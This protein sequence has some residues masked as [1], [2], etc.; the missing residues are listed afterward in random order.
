[1]PNDTIIQV[2]G[3][4]KRYGLRM[5]RWV[6]A[7]RRRHS[8]DDGPW[9]L[10]DVSLE[11][12]RGETVGVIGRNGAG[13]STLLKV[14]A[15]VTP[16]TRGR[17]EVGGSVFPMI[18]LNAGVHP[19]LSGRENVGLLG[20]IMGLTGRE[21]RAL[22]PAIEDFCEIGEWFDR[23]VRM[24]SSGMLAR[25]GLSV[26]LNVE[27]EILLVDEV[28]AVGD[29]NFRRKCV[30][31]IARLQRS[32]V[33]LLWVTHS[34]REAERMCDRGLLLEAGRLKREAAMGEVGAEY[35]AD[36][37]DEEWRRLHAEAAPHVFHDTGHVRIE[38]L[39]LLGDSGEPSESFETGRPM[40]IRMAYTVVEPVPDLTF[41]FGFVTSDLLRFTEFNS[42]D[43]P[44]P[45]GRDTRGVVE[46]R[47]PS[48]PL[49]PGV[50]GLYVSITRADLTSF[51]KGE[52]VKR[53]RVRDPGL[54]A[55]RRNTGL[56]ALDTEWT[57]AAE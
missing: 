23:P 42:L 47:L 26:A 27:A 1:M 24:Y 29:M 16:P 22:M 51:Y 41:H 7:L 4:W 31:R 36:V 32:D 49:L 20:A 12:K 53:L 57:F 54:R 19:E 46:C 14:L 28:L 6:N 33:T 50:Y 25:L 38:R 39:D 30:E 21:V 2:D 45:L 34:V 11:V 5:P 37:M 52:S 10:R 18:E 15:G 43:E 56:V 48:L 17:V 40:T 9:A 35:L 3:L 13:K 55:S 44:F 8:D